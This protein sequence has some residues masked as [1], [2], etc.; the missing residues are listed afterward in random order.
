M[1]FKLFGGLDCPDWFL[2][3]L[4][5]VSTVSS[6]SAMVMCRAAVDKIYERDIDWEMLEGVRE[7]EGLDLHQLKEVMGC[8][9]SIAVNS[10]RFDLSAPQLSHELTMLGLPKD[11]SDGVSDFIASLD[12]LPSRLITCNPRKD[13]IKSSTFKLHHVPLSSTS[14]APPQPVVQLSLTVGQAGDDRHDRAS[15]IEIPADKF[16]FLRAELMTAYDTMRKT[17]TG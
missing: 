14:S 16:R 12:T 3:L 8:M 5:T 10:T 7:A 4:A 11:I 2:S 1:K 9:H 17:S 6:E 15:N 13:T